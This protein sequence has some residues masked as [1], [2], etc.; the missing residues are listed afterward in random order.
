MPGEQ[1]GQREL[2]FGDTDLGAP[3]S[4]LQAAVDGEEDRGP[5][6]DPYGE[7]ELRFDHH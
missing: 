7:P 5:Y 6:D 1:N 3:S 4:S 2:D